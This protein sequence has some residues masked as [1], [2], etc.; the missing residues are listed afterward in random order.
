MDVNK[1]K[2]KNRTPLTESSIYAVKFSLNLDSQTEL[3][4]LLTYLL[5]TSMIT[6]FCIYV[7]FWLVGLF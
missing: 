4:R 2:L 7:G 3:Y 6:Y 5:I 1:N